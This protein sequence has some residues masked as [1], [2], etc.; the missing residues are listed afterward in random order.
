MNPGP[1]TAM[2]GTPRPA[3]RQLM[4]DLKL[5]HIPLVDSEGKL[6][7]VEVADYLDD[8]A[9]PAETEVVLMV[10]GLGTRLRP[11]TATVPKP[12]IP[13][14]GRPIL[15]SIII[16]FAEQGFRRFT[17][18]LNYK[19]EVFRQHFG[20][21]GRLGVE[22]GYVEEDDQRGTAG[23]LA[24]LARRPTRP[25]FVMNG[26]LLT[27]VNFAQLLRFHEEHQAAATMCVREQSFQIP[28]GVVSTAEHL[29]TGLE[30]KPRQVFRVNAGIYVLDPKV[31]DRIPPDRI[32]NM[33]DLFLDL[34]AAS[35]PAIAFPLREY[36]LDIGRL[37][38]LERAQSEYGK[39]FE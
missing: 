8:R 35:E 36:W 10:G 14:G 34:V 3:L 31:L 33:T 21:G 26:D 17:L 28:Y 23:A 7:G 18:A 5:H 25:F 15:E 4:S 22:I 12:M 38:D 11:I 30:E 13:V 39:V 1:H 9:P 37:E 29:I 2:A 27:A 24:L 19:G 16:S 20:D 6:V 32:Y